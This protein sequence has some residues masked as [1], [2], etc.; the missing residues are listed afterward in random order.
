M[1]FV[2]FATESC[3]D[4]RER[5]KLD[6]SMHLVQLQFVK[7]FLIVRKCHGAREEVT[8]AAFVRHCSA[9]SESSHSFQSV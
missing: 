9:A 6:T 1:S 7:G 4:D 2:L 3:A 5:L 8:F